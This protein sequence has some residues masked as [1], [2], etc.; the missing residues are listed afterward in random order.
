MAD[1]ALRLEAVEGP[2]I[3]PIDIARGEQ[4]TIGRSRECTVCLPDPTVSRQHASMAFRG[5]R[6]FVRDLHSR[7]GTLLNA[8]RLAPNLPH[9]VA[10]FDLLRIGPWTFRASLGE[11]HAN[12]ATLSDDATTAMKVQRVSPRE[13][14]E[15]RLHLILDGA[16]RINSARD[17]R[18]LGRAAVDSILAATSYDRAAML[19]SLGQEESVEVVY[20]RS[21]SEAQ[22]SAGD[23]PV[24]AGQTTR[25][26]AEYSRSLLRAASSGQVARL[27]SDGPIPF[28]ASIERLGITD[29]L[30]APVMLGGAVAAFLYLDARGRSIPVHADGADFCQAVAR[31][32]G[33]ALANLKRIDLEMRQRGLEADMAAARQAQQLIVPRDEGQLPG[34][35]YSLRMNPGS[36]VAGDLFDIFAIDERRTAVFVG[37]VTG[38]GIGAAILMSAAQSHLHAALRKHADPAAALNEVNDY[39]SERCRPGRFVSMWVGIIDREARVMTFVDAGHGHWR[40]RRAGGV[41]DPVPRPGGTLVGIDTTL[42]YENACTPVSPGDRVILY[43]DGVVDQSAPDGSRFGAARLERVLAESASPRSDV[44]SIFDAVEGFAE[45]TDLADDATVASIEIM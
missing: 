33:L 22:P 15:H 35:R 14:A 25:D 44:T 39:V 20:E 42:R 1:G 26:G 30:C 28:G 9:P 18:E 27:T 40:V 7:H 10:E 31:M 17:E 6:W 4:A 32:C 12:Q 8:V 11:R 24:A 36:F 34:V 13:L 38:E 23:T 19:R 16:T 2:A 45:T 43:S 21:R 29:A 5:E 41:I 3:E 37:D